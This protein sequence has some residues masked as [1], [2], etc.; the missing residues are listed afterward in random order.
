MKNRFDILEEKFRKNCPKSMQI[1]DDALQ[2]M[3]DSN[4]PEVT[5][6]FLMD[7]LPK[8]HQER[9]NVIMNFQ[10]LLLNNGYGNI[11]Q[12][13]GN[14]SLNGGNPYKSCYSVFITDN[15]KVIPTKKDKYFPIYTKEKPFKLLQKD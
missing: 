5:S 3:I 12:E 7:E 2:M 10:E 6:Y 15:P 9:A 1:L 8:D 14:V 13:Y 11:A 4:L